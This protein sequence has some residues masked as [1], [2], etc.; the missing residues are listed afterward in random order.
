MRDTNKVRKIIQMQ[1]TISSCE[2]IFFMVIGCWIF[3]IIFFL[4]KNECDYIT[5]ILCD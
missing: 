2:I 4:R 3:Q 1:I 5:N